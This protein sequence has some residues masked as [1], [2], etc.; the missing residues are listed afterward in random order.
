MKTNQKKETKMKAI[1]KKDFQDLYG[2][3]VYDIVGIDEAHSKMKKEI[4][5]TLYK[6]RN[7]RSTKM[8]YFNVPSN[9]IK[10]L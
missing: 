10:V 2:S 9:W 7:K 8:E 3:S 1:F 6:K 5:I 4:Q